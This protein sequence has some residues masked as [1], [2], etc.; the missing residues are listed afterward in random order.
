M[1]PLRECI[2]YVC[3]MCMVQM[4]CKRHLCEQRVSVGTVYLI[5]GKN[6]VAVKN[7]YHNGNDVHSALDAWW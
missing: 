1:S 5:V 6:W 4:N 7:H 3:S 2:P